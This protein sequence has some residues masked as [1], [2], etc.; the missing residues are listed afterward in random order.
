M[1][2]KG[3]KQKRNIAEYSTALENQCNRNADAATKVVDPNQPPKNSYKIIQGMPKR[4]DPKFQT[5]QQ[6]LGYKKLDELGTKLDAV[7]EYS[8]VQIDDEMMGI[9]VDN[10]PDRNF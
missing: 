5:S 4:V 1:E 6:R 9:S 10:I 7:A 2:E 3:L 8:L